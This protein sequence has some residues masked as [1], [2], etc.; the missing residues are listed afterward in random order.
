L[1]EEQLKDTQLKDDQ[2]QTL[3]KELPL[4]DQAEGFEEKSASGGDAQFCADRRAGARGRRDA[5]I[6]GG[7]RSNPHGLS[8]HY[9]GGF[10]HRAAF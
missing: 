9:H 7:N 2:N 8:T 5:G 6:V 3:E 10:L 4:A 1:K